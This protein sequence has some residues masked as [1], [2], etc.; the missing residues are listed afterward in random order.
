MYSITVCTVLI[1]GISQKF[2]TG[3]ASFQKSGKA[4]FFGMPLNAKESVR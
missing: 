1:A 2:K 3:L 4:N